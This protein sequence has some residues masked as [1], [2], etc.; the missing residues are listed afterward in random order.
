MKGLKPGKNVQERRGPRYPTLCGTQWDEVWKD[1]M[2]F[3]K[4]TGIGVYLE[5]W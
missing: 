4:V 1:P 3:N 5:G 2:E